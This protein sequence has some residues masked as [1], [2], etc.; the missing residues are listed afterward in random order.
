MNL[1]TPKGADRNK[2]VPFFRYPPS[3]NAGF[4]TLKDDHHHSIV[5]KVYSYGYVQ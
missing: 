3:I 2:S 1:N 4:N 5:H